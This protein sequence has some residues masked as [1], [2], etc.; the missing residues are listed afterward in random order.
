MKK[1]H[2]V[3]NL[4]ILDESGSMQRIKNATI[5][6]FNEVVQTI[7]AVEQKFPEQSHSITFI[8]FNSG[9][10]RTLLFNEPASSIEQIDA[11]K[12]QP[13]QMTPLYD[14]MGSGISMV[15]QE[16][17]KCKEFH[18]LVT[19]L[20]DGMENASRE[21]TKNQIKELVKEL[22]EQNWTFTYIGAN[23]DVETVA[24]SLSIHNSLHFHANDEDMKKMFRKEGNS[25]IAY[26]KKIAT[27][28]DTKK[29]YF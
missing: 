5:D 27:K 14:A 16:T 3:F 9:G 26:C 29:G 1:K 12:Y 7:K 28:K 19:I 20:T 4:I 15:R 8:S 10:I 11:K 17:A 18:V 6:G 22:T 24:L 23:H 2:Q 25:R 13:G 21:Y